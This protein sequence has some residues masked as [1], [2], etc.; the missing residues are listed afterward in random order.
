MEQAQYDDAFTTVLHKHFDLDIETVRAL[1]ELGLIVLDQ[2]SL[3][4]IT[5]PAIAVIPDLIGQ[6]L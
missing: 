4:E 2:T 1:D 5:N 6:A 3:N